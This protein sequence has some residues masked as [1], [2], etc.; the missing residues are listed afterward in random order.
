MPK[1]DSV[2]LQPTPFCNISCRYC[3]LPDRRNTSKMSVETLRQVFGQVFSSGWLSEKLDVIWHAGEPLVLTVD[4]YRTAFREIKKLTPADVKVTHFFQTNGM[5]INDDWCTF[6]EES[7]SK[8]GVS[9]DGPDEINDANRVTRS[10]NSTLDQTIAGIKCLQ[11][12]SIEFHVITVLTLNS[13][14]RARDLYEFYEKSGITNVCFN[15]EE[16]EGVN[17]NSSLRDPKYA[18]LF[19]NFLRE[20]WNILIDRKTIKYVREFDS[21][22]KNIVSPIGSAI[23][24]TLV[25]PFAMVNVDWQGNFSTFSPELL[26]MK[27]NRYGD[28]ILGNLANTSLNQTLHD[29]AFQVFDRD[30]FAG[31]EECRNTCEY[32]GICGGGAPA[33]KLYENG[34][35]ISTET[36]YCRLRI[37]SLSNVALEIIENTAK[38]MTST[39]PVTTILA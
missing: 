35:F 24:N 33:N 4:Y 32:F 25:E 36:M 10:G 38:E 11:R 7:D 31:V 39:A 2:V 18:I 14:S 22:L 5:L 21:I 30:V 9:I 19:E 34:T 20:F 3:Y 27:N 29:S 13:L 16:I 23:E 26:G 28:F 17:T 12:H 8:I 1:I 37:K 15:V 6:F